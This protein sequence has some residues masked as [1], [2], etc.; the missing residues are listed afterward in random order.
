MKLPKLIVIKG[1]LLHA[2]EKYIAHQ[3]NC[4]T[5]RAAHLSR[6]VFRKFPHADIYSKRNIPDKPGTIIV[7]GDGKRQ[8]YVINMLGQ[9][10]PGSPKFQG[11]GYDTWRHRESYFNCCLHAILRLSNLDSIAFPYGIGCGAAGGDWESYRDML[12]WF[13]SKVPGVRVV[14]Y[15]FSGAL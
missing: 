1:N 15:S 10:Y 11:M 7:R 14:C 12:R 9:I 4:V 6:D 5:H 8:R 3:T 2:S 13:T